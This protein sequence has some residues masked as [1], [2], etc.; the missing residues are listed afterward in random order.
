MKIKS[1][2]VFI[3]SGLIL[4]PYTGDS[5][6]ASPVEADIFRLINLDEI[7]ENIK[8]E[9]ISKYK[10]DEAGFESEYNSFIDNIKK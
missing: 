4:N 9:I 2:I 10:I 8:T 7:K 6:V 3:D 5:F 1:H